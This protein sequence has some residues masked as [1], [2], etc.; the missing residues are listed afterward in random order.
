MILRCG[1]RSRKSA[2][3]LVHRDALWT[4]VAAESGLGMW[5]AK[6]QKQQQ[7]GQDMN[8][9]ELKLTDTTNN[10]IHFLLLLYP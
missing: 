2:G 5:A 1:A 6:Q 3:L 9:D 8:G 10:Y 4:V 7:I